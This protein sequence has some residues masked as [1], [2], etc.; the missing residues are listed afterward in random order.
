M[1]QTPTASASSQNYESIFDNALKVYRKKT[2]VDL[3]SEPLL[4]KLQTCNSPDAV[5]TVLRERIS[6]QSCSTSDVH[7]RLTNW[8]N[9]TVNVLHTFSVA[10][11]GGI[12]MVSIRQSVQCQPIRELIFISMQAYPPAGVIFAGIGVL[13]SVGTFFDFAAL[14][15]VTPRSPRPSRPSQIAKMHSLTHLRE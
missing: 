13:L 14:A 4:T 2:R 7:A 11:G 8:L 9:P 3:R 6:D 1:S 15:E 12:S 10:I 5:L